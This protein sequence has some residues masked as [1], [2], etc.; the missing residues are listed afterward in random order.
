MSRSRKTS[1]M[2]RRVRIDTTAADGTPLTAHATLGPE[3]TP[4]T[5][6][7]L[8]SLMVAVHE[9]CKKGLL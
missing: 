6:E 3:A 4:K 9:A 5:V 1:R 7:A 2:P 8:R